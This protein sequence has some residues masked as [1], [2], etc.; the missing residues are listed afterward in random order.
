MLVEAQSHT[1]RTSDK[2]YSKMIFTWPQCA[3]R[4]SVR[5]SCNALSGFFSLTTVPLHTRSPAPQS[6]S[7]RTLGERWKTHRT[8]TSSTLPSYFRELFL[9]HRRRTMSSIFTI[10]RARLTVVFY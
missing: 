5:A 8:G 6:S 9:L 1:L 4:F 10:N 3:D 7:T 2:Y